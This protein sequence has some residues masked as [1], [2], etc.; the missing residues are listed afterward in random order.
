MNRGL[1]NSASAILALNRNMEVRSHNISNV[2]TVG[3]KYNNYHNDV[4]ED[5]M[6]SYQ[7]NKVGTLPT[8]VGIDKISTVLSQ[9]ALINTTRQLDVAITGDGY[10][11]VER[12]NGIYSYT[13]N[14]NFKIDEQGFLVDF[15]G[16]YIMGQNGRIN[17]E[18]A[19]N[20]TI[21]NDGSIVQ[22]GS[23]V[24]KL[25]VTALNNPDKQTLTYFTADNEIEGEF[26]IHQGYLE[27]SNVDMAK[28]MVDVISIQRLLTTNSKMLQAE[29]ELNKKMIDSIS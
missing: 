23:I 9:G 25:Y 15:N 1:Y 29:D 12:G 27:A 14:G 19:E 21:K 17:L 20:V 10:I 6:L 11:K 16:N 24:D 5:V 2:G 13:R 4:F 8:R 26:S 3:Y 18:S 22:N 28:E 7:G